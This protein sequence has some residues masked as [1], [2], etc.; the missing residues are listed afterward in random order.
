MGR[1]Q[2][3]PMMAMVVE[4]VKWSERPSPV[5]GGSRA[6]GM[7]GTSAQ[8]AGDDCYGMACKHAHNP[9]KKCVAITDPVV[10]SPLCSMPCV[11]PPPKK[12][13]APPAK[14]GVFCPAP[15]T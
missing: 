6:K 15:L 11:A 12:K 13:P 14:P 10:G 9:Y 1:R 3:S 7:G 4:L 2:A 5:R 8:L